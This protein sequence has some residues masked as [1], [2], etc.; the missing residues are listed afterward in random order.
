MKNNFV[1]ERIDVCKICDEVDTP[2]FL[3]SEHKLQENYIHFKKSFSKHYSNIRIDYSAKTNFELRILKILRRLGLNISISSGQELFLAKKAGFKSSQLA[4]DGPSKSK[5]EICYGLDEGIYVFNVYS[6]EELFL[7]NK[8]ASDKKKTVNITFRVHLRVGSKFFDMAQVYVSRF[9]IPIDKVLDA[10]K[11]ALSLDN[12]KIIGIS[13]HIGSQ[14]TRLNLYLKSIE[15]LIELAIKLE[16]LGVNVNEINL[17]GGFPSRSLEKTSLRHLFGIKRTHIP[18]IEEFGDEI[19]KK[20]SV[21]AGQLKGN[22]ILTFQ[23]GRSIVSDAGILVSRVTSIK[24][25]WVFVDASNNFLPESLLFTQRR[26]LVANKVNFHA[27]KKY[28]L[29]GRTLC[30]DI[31]ALKKKLPILEVGDIIVFLDAGAYS[32]VRANRFTTLNPPIYLITRDG[33]IE[34]I[35]RKENYE[36][37]ISP[38]LY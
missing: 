11:K 25:K 22:P 21:L 38:M 34:M 13:T 10:Y 9:G 24:G 6:L 15:K 23:P 12:I 17:G 33:K 32:I 27:L 35:R 3:F 8:I 4:F 28:N 16:K 26:I 1:F 20:F 36:D 2:Y 5:D 30:A 14:V 18:S 19:S 7:L 31:L 29:A 37:L